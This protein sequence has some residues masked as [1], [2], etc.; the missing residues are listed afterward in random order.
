MDDLVLWHNDA[1]E[2]QKLYQG[3]T[4]L[5]PDHSIGNE[6]P[7]WHRADRVFRFWLLIQA[8]RDLPAPQVK[9]RMQNTAHR[10]HADLKRLYRRSNSAALRAVSVNA[11]VSLARTR[12]FVYP[13]GRGRP[14]ARIALNGAAAGTTMPPLHVALSLQQTTRTT[15]TTTSVFVLVRP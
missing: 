13:C 15:R 2:L 1:A 10:I 11:A 5:S 3:S 4:A 8:R 9:K 6:T 7:L 14:R 12:G